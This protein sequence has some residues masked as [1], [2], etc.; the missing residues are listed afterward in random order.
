MQKL[1]EKKI[2]LLFGRINKYTDKMIEA[3]KK[4]YDDEKYKLMSRDIFS[5]GSDS[6]GSG[7]VAKFGEVISS[8]VSTVIVIEHL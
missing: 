5:E 7:L 8:M 4:E 3:F 2:H 6:A 1:K